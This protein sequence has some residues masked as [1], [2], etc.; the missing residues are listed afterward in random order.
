MLR[1]YDAPYM[2]DWFAISLRWIM[3]VGLIVS[4]G[5]GGKLAI[6]ISWPL[7]LL[8]AW[9][10]AMTG[11]AGLNLRMAFHRPINM[12]G[13]LILAGAFYWAQGGLRGPAVWTGLLPILTGS[14]YFELLGALIASLLFSGL[15]IFT[16]MQVDGDLPL[17][18]TISATLIVLG[19]IFGFLGLRMIA[20]MRKNR[21]LWLDSEEKKNAMQAERMRAIEI[22]GIR[23][24]PVDM[25]KSPFSM[26]RRISPYASNEGRRGART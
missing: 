22:S 11:L 25:K 18:I 13:D 19:L 1:K 24:S 15:M 20:H 9:N 14:I 3:L 7:G 2:A 6:S 21:A 4:L 17:A 5:L 23:T 8:I 26:V 10:L 16:G 12:L